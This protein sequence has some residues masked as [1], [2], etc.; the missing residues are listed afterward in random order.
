MPRTARSAQPRDRGRPVVARVDVPAVR[1]GSTRLR[2]TAPAGRRATCLRSRTPQPW[3][4]ACTAARARR[5]PAR[6]P[7]PA[8]TAPTGCSSAA[9][10]VGGSRPAWPRQHVARSCWASRTRA[11]RASGP[12]RTP[13]ASARRR[14]ETAAISAAVRVER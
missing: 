4:R 14:P 2:T 3:A 12:R 11:S 13:P 10:T 6:G 7:V 9:R 1:A 5:P 8:R